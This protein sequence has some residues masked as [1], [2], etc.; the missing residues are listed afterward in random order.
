MLNQKLSPALIPSKPIRLGPVALP[1]HKKKKAGN[2][3][4][5]KDWGM[6]HTENSAASGPIR[7]RPGG[8]GG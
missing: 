8:L 1:P 5:L 3:A 4:G 6:N 7:P 2:C